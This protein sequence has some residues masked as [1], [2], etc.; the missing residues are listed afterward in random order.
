MNHPVGLAEYEQ[1]E[2]ELLDL[3]ARKPE[4]PVLPA[5]QPIVHRLPLRVKEAASRLDMTDQALYRWIGQG[6]IATIRFGRNIRISAE[7]V[8]RL[9]LHGLQPKSERIN[10]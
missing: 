2:Q 6:R 1:W 7:E 5:E 4:F 3:L 9:A 10:P 8:D